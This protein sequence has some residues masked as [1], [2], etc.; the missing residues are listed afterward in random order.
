MKGFEY[1]ERNQEEFA[2]LS[3]VMTFFSKGQAMRLVN[4]YDFSNFRTVVDVGGG[5]GYLLTAILKNYPSLQ[6]I[7]YELP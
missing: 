4:S 2:I 7:L 3:N 1:F 5:H 6:G